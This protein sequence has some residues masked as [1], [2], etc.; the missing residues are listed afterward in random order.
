M[1]TCHRITN[2]TEFGPSNF[3]KFN[4]LSSQTY[5]SAVLLKMQKERL[6]STNMAATVEVR[7]CLRAHL[8][9]VVRFL[10]GGNHDCDTFD[11]TLFRLDWVLNVLARYLD[12]ETTRADARIVHLVREAREAATNANHSRSAD[13]FQAGSIF[14]GQRGRPKIDV[15]QEQLQFLVESHS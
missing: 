2:L 7:E 4:S 8:I 12:T 9:D 5:L 1:S 3:A 15:T 10:E 14:T 13:A 11:Y 6:L